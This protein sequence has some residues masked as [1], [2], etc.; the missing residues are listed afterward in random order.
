MIPEPTYRPATK[1]E[2]QSVLD[3]LSYYCTTV[4]VVDE[5]YLEIYDIFNK[6]MTGGLMLPIEDAIKGKNW[7]V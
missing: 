2:K 4:T 3:A 7:K 1:K 5:E 6:I